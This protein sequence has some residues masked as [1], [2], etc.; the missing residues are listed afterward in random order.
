[1][2]GGYY[3]QGRAPDVHLFEYAIDFENEALVLKKERAA[4]SPGFQDEAG[5][6]IPDPTG[7]LLPEPSGA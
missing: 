5:F 6:I 2:Y 3:R 4:P 1:M 7:P